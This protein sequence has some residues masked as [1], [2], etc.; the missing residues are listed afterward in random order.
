MAKK[1]QCLYVSRF[2]KLESLKN[3]SVFATFSWF[4]VANGMIPLPNLPEPDTSHWKIPPR[5]VRWDYQE[6]TGIARK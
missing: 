4:A 2:Y 5:D 6:V 3:T 1:D